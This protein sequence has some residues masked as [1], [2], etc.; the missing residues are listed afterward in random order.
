MNCARALL[1]NN[2][3]LRAA[4]RA[5][6]GRVGD[7]T[8]SPPDRSVEQLRGIAAP[9]GL[10]PPIPLPFHQSVRPSVRLSVYPYIRPSDCGRSV[11]QL[12]A[13]PSGFQDVW[14]T[15]NRVTAP[16]P[17]NSSSHPLRAHRRSISRSPHRQSSPRSTPPPPSSPRFLCFSL[18]LTLFTQETSDV[19]NSRVATVEKSGVLVET[20]PPVRSRRE[21]RI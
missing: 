15:S 6:R 19:V 16:R 17:L 9:L 21:K 20:R 3:I 1:T 8:L 7:A 12:A 11:D 2:S 14:T 5:P 10:K 4:A 18:D 13:R